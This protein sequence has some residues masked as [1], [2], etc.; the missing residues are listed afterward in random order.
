MAS[1][2]AKLVV[3]ASSKTSGK[4]SSKSSSKASSKASSN[5]SSTYALHVDIAERVDDRVQVA[6]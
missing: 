5:G 1:S 3:Q 4:A 2:K 6:F